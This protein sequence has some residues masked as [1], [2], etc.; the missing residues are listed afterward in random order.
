MD[1]HE[2]ELEPLGVA[3]VFKH[4]VCLTKECLYTTPENRQAPL[5]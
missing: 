2:G 5:S 3:K 1:I 4:Y